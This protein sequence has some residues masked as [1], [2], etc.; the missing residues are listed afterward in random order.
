[1]VILFASAL[2]EGFSHLVDHAH[3]E[4][5]EVMSRVNDTIGVFWNVTFR[6]ILLLP[7]SG[8]LTDQFLYKSVSTSAELGR[9]NV[10][11]EF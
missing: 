3:E 11:R 8:T 10:K 6:R 1:M 9:P 2:L 7:S 5:F 4:R